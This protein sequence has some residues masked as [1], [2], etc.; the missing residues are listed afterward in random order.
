[1]TDY[2]ARRERANSSRRPRS[3]SRPTAT[4]TAARQCHQVSRGTAI[5]HRREGLAQRRIWSATRPTFYLPK[6]PTATAKRTCAKS[7]FTGF[8]THNAQARV[9]SL[10]YGL[11]NW[12]YGSCGLFGGK[13]TQLHRPRR[14]ISATA[15]SACAPT[16]AKSSRS[17]AKRSRAGPRRLGQLVRLRQRHAAGSLPV[18]E[19]TMLAR[20]PHVP[21][22]R[23]ATR[24]R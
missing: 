22:P 20:N 21:R 2:P 19:I 3:L 14:S 1:M 17:P 11:D 15:T 23:P 13:I 9:N 10:R 12:L 6:T 8:A 24:F 7:L 16:P 4:A 5:S 18:V